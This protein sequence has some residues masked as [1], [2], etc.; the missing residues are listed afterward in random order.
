MYWNDNTPRRAVSSD[1]VT[2][3]V[4]VPRMVKS[5]GMVST[6]FGQVILKYSHL[7]G[8]NQ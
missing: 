7:A 1:G 4:T 5:Q 6:L 3:V 8:K 2:L